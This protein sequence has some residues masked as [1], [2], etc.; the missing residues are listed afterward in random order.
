MARPM[1][2]LAPVMMMPPDAAAG[3]GDDDGFVC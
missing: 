2:R 1:P 3:A